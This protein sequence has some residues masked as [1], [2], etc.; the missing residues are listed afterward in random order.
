VPLDAVKQY[1]ESQ[2]RSEMRK[3]PRGKSVQV[4]E[5]KYVPP[6]RRPPLTLR[7]WVN[8]QESPRQDTTAFRSHDIVRRAGVVEMVTQLCAPITPSR[9]VSLVGDPQGGWDVGGIEISRMYV[10][11]V[12][13]GAIPIDL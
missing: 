3:Q 5:L 6:T 11:R 10:G 8:G 4:P 1:I 12:A 7:T 13:V 2:E 9:S